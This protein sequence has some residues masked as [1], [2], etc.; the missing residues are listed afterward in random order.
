MYYASSEFIFRTEDG[1]AGLFDIGACSL[2]FWFS[3]S[4]SYSQFFV[5]SFC[6]SRS[7]GLSLHLFFHRLLSNSS[8]SIRVP[9]VGRSVVGWLPAGPPQS[10]A[11]R[12]TQRE[13]ENNETSIGLFPTLSVRLPVEIASQFLSSRVPRSLARA[14]PKVSLPQGGEVAGIRW[15]GKSGRQILICSSVQTPLPVVLR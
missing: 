6:F 11:T 2:L 14:A 15:A 12:H 5:F 7:F 13:R 9:D 1:F 10:I 8:Y 4:S 3:S